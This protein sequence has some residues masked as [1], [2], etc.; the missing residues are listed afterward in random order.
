MKH[1]TIEIFLFID[2][3][4]WKIVND[5]QFLSD[6]LPNRKKI[7]MQFGYSSSAIPTILSGKTP[8]E[9]G[10]LGLFRFAPDASP[11]KTLSRLACF[12]KP[13]SFWNRGRVRHHLSK[14]LKKIYGFTGYFQLYRMPLWKLKYMDYCEKQDLFIANGMEN[15]ANLHDT[16]NSRGVNFHI[17][18]WH[19]NDQENYLAAE[20]AI[21]NGK[22]FLFV[23]TASLDGL[24]HDKIMDIPAIRT[25]LDE[26][27]EQIESLYQKATQHCD[28]V[29]F[30]IIS[31]HGMTP[32]AGT[33][34]IM[35][36]MEGCG[37]VF[38]K[39]YGACYDSTMA[40][41]YYLNEKAKPVITELMQKF[42]GHFLSKEDEIKYGIYRTDRAF[43]DAIFLLDAGIQ[44][45]PSDMG[46]KPLNGMHG[47]IPEN[48]HSYAVLLSNSPLP[49]HVTKV[50]DYFNFMIERSET[51]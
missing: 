15:I 14:L 11:F 49:D 19:L 9:H 43:G 30:T 36:E 29:H 13:A 26:I 47:F 12:F 38:G 21:E 35:K 44:I 10:H 34:D 31:D 46:G 51:L 32:L 25:K 20:R 3:L 40:R 23:Y 2:A 28:D 48:E 1:K 6:F 27:R 7:F 33:V 8:A 42:P 24:L 18:D 22:N 16:L 17:S 39:D 45:V 37:L 4:G 50:A 41:F 5:H